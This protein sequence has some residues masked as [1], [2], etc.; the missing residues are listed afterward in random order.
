MRQI[1]ALSLA[2]TLAA[3]PAQAQINLGD[4]LRDVAEEALSE[5]QTERSFSGISETDAD[6]GLR[7]ALAIGV[8]VAVSDLGVLDG[9]W[10]SD[11]FRLP[12]PG[13]LGDAQRA[14]GRMGLS[15][16][17]DDLQRQLNR[18]A[19]DAVPEAKELALDVVNSLT[20]ED[21]IGLLQGGET[22]AT[23]LLEA[24]TRA[25]LSARF[26]PYIETALN[27]SGAIQAADRAFSSSS[28]S[29]TL[30]VM[31]VTSSSLKN[32]LTDGAVDGA[33]DALYRRLAMEEAAIRSD[34]GKQTTALLQRVFGG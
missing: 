1:F 17:L 4:L 34:P 19:E 21:A 2:A 10:G 9:F 6:A 31:G 32:D 22:A 24:K 20:I 14:L 5:T 16:P 27:D 25:T 8:D 11:E 29:A 13:R 33:L 28:A 18:A 26:R 30:A 15:G 3:L 12:L 23:D 7:E